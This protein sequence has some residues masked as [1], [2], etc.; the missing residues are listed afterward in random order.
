MW[1]E[2]KIHTYAAYFPSGLSVLQYRPTLWV[3]LQCKRTCTHT[4]THTE[5][6]ILSFKTVYLIL[7][8]KIPLMFS[9]LFFVAWSHYVINE[10]YRVRTILLVRTKVRQKDFVSLSTHIWLFDCYP[11]ICFHLTLWINR[12]I[13]ARG[14]I[15]I[16]LPHLLFRWWKD[17]T[18]SFSMQT[19]CHKCCI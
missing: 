6:S 15:W 4:H 16:S 17:L 8:K 18:S 12:K 11:N 19:I 13:W 2:N 10:K 7:T 5:K 14:T 3:R 9:S 1:F